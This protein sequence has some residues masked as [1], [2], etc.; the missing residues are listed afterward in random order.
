MIDY[1]FSSYMFAKISIIVKFISGPII[2][3]IQETKS[4]FRKFKN[5][6]DSKSNFKTKSEMSNR[7]SKVNLFEFHYELK[8]RLITMHMAYELDC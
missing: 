2:I 8:S 6:E 7:I 5:K 3:A 1:R 4:Y